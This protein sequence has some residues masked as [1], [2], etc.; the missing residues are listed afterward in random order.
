MGS[1]DCP[2]PSTALPRL[3][4]ADGSVQG[5]PLELG[6]GGWNSGSSVELLCGLGQVVNSL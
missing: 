2:D 1:A 4:E 3:A 5:P 6:R